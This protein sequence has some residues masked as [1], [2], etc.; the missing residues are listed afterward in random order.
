MEQ[1]LHS[2]FILTLI[3]A[4]CRKQAKEMKKIPLLL[5]ALV[6]LDLVAR[7]TVS[8]RTKQDGK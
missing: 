3:Q 4:M 6:R 2:W 5:Q 7:Q 8:R 1:Y